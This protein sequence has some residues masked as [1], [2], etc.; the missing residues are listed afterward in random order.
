MDRYAGFVSQ[1]PEEIMQKAEKH[2]YNDIALFKPESFVTGKLMHSDDFHVIISSVPPPDTY[3]NGKL[4]CFD[5]KKIIAFNPGDTI[6]SIEEGTKKQYIS[7]LIK[8]ELVNRIAEQM[9]HSGS[10]RFLKLQN[11]YSGELIQ[12]IGALVK[13]I[14]RRDRLPMMLDSICIQIVTLLLREFK[15]NLKKYPENYPDADVY[16]AVSTDYIHTFFN[17]NITI[18]DIC[19][20]INLSP[21]HFIRIFREKTGVS[22]HQYL[23][24]VRIGKAEEILRSGNYSVTETALLCGFVSLPHFSSTFK[25]IT[26]HSPGEYKKLYLQL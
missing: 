6:L 23:L 2:M 25:K 3:V 19:N 16:V 21:F 20:E 5:I 1:I 13:E 10:I 12:A 24:K 11:P 8:P 17:A 22:P 9:D 7:L 26:G 14:G 4:Q 18:E 15:T